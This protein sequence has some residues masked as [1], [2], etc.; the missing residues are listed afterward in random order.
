MRL[1]AVVILAGSVTP[2]FAQCQLPAPVAAAVAAMPSRLT[3]FARYRTEA[4]TYLDFRC[5]EEAEAAQRRASESGGAKWFPAMREF[6]SARIAW[7]QGRLA[8]AK[9]AFDRL[10]D[11]SYPQ[12]VNFRAALAL[13]EL[14]NQHP[15]HALWERFRPRLELLANDFGHWRARHYLYTYNL[16][17]ATAGARVQELKR[18][19]DREL[20]VRLRMEGLF[21]LGD[22]LYR[23]K[24]TLEAML[25]T[26]SVE[27][28]F[29][30]SVV[31]VEL[32]AAFLR[33][34]AA[35]WSARA[36]DGDP[37]A[38]ARAQTYLRAVQQAYDPR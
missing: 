22:V 27:E 14:L 13:A 23:S 31:D 6:V 36:R 37:E 8:E 3:G 26:T 19:L 32:R 17:E 16:T 24:R 12:D 18:M 9:A 15:D 21:I 34:C 28:E 1:V 30:D 2:G 10:A 11:E 38:A 29:G 33:L 4:L 20:P 5:F 7:N 35:I 25:L